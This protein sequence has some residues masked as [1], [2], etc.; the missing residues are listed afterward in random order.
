MT[1]PFVK[2]KI[3]EGVF[4]YLSK[5]TKLDFD[6]K[7]FE[8]TLKVTSSSSLKFG[9]GYPR[10]LIGLS[11]NSYFQSNPGDNNFWVCFD[12]KEREI[13][14]SNYSIRSCADYDGHLRSW[15]IE[16]SNNNKS[17]KKIDEHDNYSELRGSNITKSFEVRPN[18]FARYCRLR[19]TSECW[20]SEN[21]YTLRLQNIEFYGKLRPNK[22]T[23][24]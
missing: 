8:K 4:Y 24:V 21:R 13:E 2:D 20:G 6:D 10:N 1:I 14:V 18:H 7:D 19:Q 17:W 16:I 22:L 3:L 15:V 23:D 9:Y 11:S 12:F 5:I